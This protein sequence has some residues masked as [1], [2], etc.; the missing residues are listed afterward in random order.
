MFCN[1]CR[2]VNPEDAVYCSACG[3]TIRLR[4]EE[5]GSRQIAQVSEN[6]SPPVAVVAAEVPKTEPEPTPVEIPAATIPAP[7]LNQPEALTADAATSR[8]VI[9][10]SGQQPAIYLTYGTMGQR[11]AAYFADLIVIY[12]IVVFVSFLAAA[13]EHPLP[14]SEGAS[15]LMV[16][17]VLFV[18]MIVA[19]AIYHT[20]IGKYMQGLEVCSEQVRRG[21]TPRFGELFC[22]R[23][24]VGCSL[25]S[26]GAWA[27]GWRSE[28]QNNKL[29]VTSSPEPL[30]CGD[31]RTR[32]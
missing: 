30:S 21:C 26:F 10:P 4:S 8:K 14:T 25:F 18:Y 15:E 9:L 12:L 6:G 11:F 32:Y 20:T 1:Y 3:R 2:A 29:G 28:N 24:S 7:L 16:F 17:V 23:H 31:Q 22:G 27:I 13:F 19:Q 5:S